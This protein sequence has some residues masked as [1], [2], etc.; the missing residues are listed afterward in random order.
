MSTVRIQLYCW[1]LS[2]S[3]SHIFFGNMSFELYY[4]VPRMKDD[5]IILAS[6]LFSS[7]P[8]RIFSVCHERLVKVCW[9]ILVTAATAKNL[10]RIKWPG[11]KN[12]LRANCF[13]LATRGNGWDHQKQWNNRKSFLVVAHCSCA[14]I[15]QMIMYILHRWSLNC[16]KIWWCCLCSFWWKLSW[17]ISQVTVLQLRAVW[18]EKIKATFLDAWSLMCFWSSNRIRNV[19]AIVLQRQGLEKANCA[20]TH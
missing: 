12:N 16:W 1:H 9:H 5:A 19:M 2:S 8:M 15:V 18:H 6:L 13:S 20:E 11:Q 3:D 17:L 10:L 14:K 7:A 4:S